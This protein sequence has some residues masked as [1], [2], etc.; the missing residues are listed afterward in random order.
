[1]LESNLHTRPSFLSKQQKHTQML[2][3][4]NTALHDI[5]S[6]TFEKISTAYL[7]TLGH[8]SKQ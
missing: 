3:L 6:A 4:I 7:V 2:G 1:M 8:K 5:Y